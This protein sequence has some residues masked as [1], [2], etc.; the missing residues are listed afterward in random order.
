MIAGIGSLELAH[1]RLSA[2]YG[3][4]PDASVWRR[5]EH[6][7][8]LPALV[9][10]ARTSPLARWISE[11]TP[12]SDSHDIE[13]AL[14]DQWRR[15][16]SE[17]AA[18]MPEQWQSA[19]LWWTTWIDLPVLEYLARG[20]TP[21]PWMAGDA[22]YCDLQSTSA[23]AQATGSNVRQLMPALRGLMV[24]PESM[25]S[26]WCDAWRARMPPGQSGVSF[27]NELSRILH[28]HLASFA[29]QA[30]GD[31]WPSRRELDKRLGTLFRKSLLQ[32][33]AA[34]VY[35]ALTALDLERLRAELVRRAIFTP[36]P[37]ARALA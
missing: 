15:E 23:D 16:V 2:R 27:L 20:G 17:V 14:R 4:R 26:R 22:V 10:A 8:A 24:R 9:D 32:P 7:R 11:L 33:T 1:A 6:I 19:V 21:L 29:A 5:V 12:G 13:R 25:L 35:L 3:G 36:E 18:W 34:F 28:G 30:V 31:G 37:T